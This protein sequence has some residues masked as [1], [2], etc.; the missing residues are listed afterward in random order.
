MGSYLIGYVPPEKNHGHADPLL[1]EL[2]YGDKGDNGKKLWNHVQKGDHIFFH[3]T[4][5]KKRYLTAFYVVEAV[6]LV[7]DAKNNPDIFMKYN[8]PHLK[9]ELLD[10]FETIIFGNLITSRILEAPLE[11]T[12]E[13]LER[14]SRKANLNKEQEMQAAIS[15]ALRSWKALSDADVTLLKEQ[16]NTNQNSSRLARR[17]FST[18]EIFQVAERD[19]ESFVIEHPEVFGQ[20]IR[21]HK[22]QHVLKK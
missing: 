5:R 10:P 19:I 8:N 14:L 9:K 20:D 4:I 15:S 17:L 12:E 2:T 3:T 18:E 6:M 16:I 11:I 7:K 22:S 13:L 21:V 1:E